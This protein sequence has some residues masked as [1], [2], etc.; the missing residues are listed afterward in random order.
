LL[1]QAPLQETVPA[2]QPHVPPVQTSLVPHDV[3]LATGFG[4]QLCVVAPVDTHV[5]ALW[6]ES[7]GQ[8]TGLE[9]VHT[10]LLQE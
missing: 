7:P 5:P 10:P 8:D 3:P 6:Q 4:V 2:E 1:T 9:P